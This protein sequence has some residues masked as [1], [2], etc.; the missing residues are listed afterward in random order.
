MYFQ[1]Q[2]Q[3]SGR[4]RRW[5]LATIASLALAIVMSSTVLGA[6]P[7]A[8]SG[9]VGTWVSIDCAT[10]GDGGVDCETWGDGSAMS[11]TIGPGETP[12]VTF[13]DSFASVCDRNGSPATRFVAT[14]VGTYED[15]FL[16]VDFPRSG[17]GFVKT[18]P[19]T[20]QL[21]HDPGSD[22]LWEDEDGDG[23]GYI[24]YRAPPSTPAGA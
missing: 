8:F 5:P 3:A 24:W 2:R 9:F 21:Y 7:P 18:G 6:V 20:F 19:V 13:Q 10:S 22:T 1:R 17:C 15:I 12:L 14:G 11:M 4:S 23:L 16:W